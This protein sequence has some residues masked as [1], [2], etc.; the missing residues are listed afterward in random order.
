MRKIVPVDSLK[1][2]MYVEELDRPWLG[3]PF[4]LQGFVVETADDI[5]QLRRCCRFVYVDGS[6]SV[7]EAYEAPPPRE[8][9]AARRGTAPPPLT[10]STVDN[11]GRDFYEIIR[12][13]RQA[14]PAEAP[15]ARHPTPARPV[16]PIREIDRQSE[17]EEEILYAEPIYE[18]LHEALKTISASLDDAGRADFGLVK[19]NF[20]EVAKSVQRNPDAA[21]WL[22]RLRQTDHYTYDHS[23]DVSVHLMVFGRFLGMPETTLNTLGLAG[24][25]CD[26]GKVHVSPETLAKTEPLTPEEYEHLKSHVASSL[27]IVVGQGDAEPRLLEIVSRHHERYDG[28]GY[29]RGLSGK[30]I[31]LHAE[32]AGIVDTYCAITRER[33]YR[34]A[35]SNQAAL[36]QLNR[37][38]GSKFREP[39]VDQFIQCIGL[40]PLGTLVELSTGEVA[41]VIAQN[42][43]RRLKPR[44]MI[45][46]GA[47]K[48]PERRPRNLDLIAD[49][50]APNG[51]PYRI[52]RSLPPNAYGIDPH[53]FYLI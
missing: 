37:M 45:L 8:K 41:V 53:E 32:M 43:V 27:E 17:L 35:V 20:A 12:A 36:E 40:Y 2:G 44:V 15:A 4:L 11:T 16:P 48:V 51:E 6:R 26:V 31:G 18:A 1:T 33:P 28:S 34:P 19:E 24:L 29:P 47:D 38:R 52:I 21:I 39:V 49:P 22:T 14:R 5:E 3:T 50:Q 42:Q 46:L 23:L 25:M 13:V 10:V 7:G 9:P 30:K